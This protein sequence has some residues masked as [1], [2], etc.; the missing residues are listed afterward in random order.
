MLR[1]LIPFVSSQ[2]TSHRCSAQMRLSLRFI[3]SKS[4]IRDRS[5]AHRHRF[6]NTTDLGIFL[7]R[8]EFDHETVSKIPDGIDTELHFKN[9][10][11]LRNELNCVIRVTGLVRRSIA[12]LCTVLFLPLIHCRPCLIVRCRCDTPGSINH[13]PVQ[14]IRAACAQR[15][16][17]RMAASRARVGLAW[18]VAERVRTQLL[19]I[20]FGKV[21]T[22]G[23][24]TA[25]SKVSLQSELSSK[26]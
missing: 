19:F 13:L 24:V 5:P 22:T 17:H 9:S 7:F 12:L 8:S 20:I 14:P 3:N 15:V 1:R 2:W 18:P 16:G 11:S 23:V 4:P 25:H 10:R 21:P 26:F 6:R